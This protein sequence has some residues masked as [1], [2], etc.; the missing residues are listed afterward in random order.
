MWEELR[1]YMY[2]DIVYIFHINSQ[3]KPGDSLQTSLLI[4]QA[5]AKSI[6]NS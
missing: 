6:F 4:T 1:K 5:L 2:M 3:Q